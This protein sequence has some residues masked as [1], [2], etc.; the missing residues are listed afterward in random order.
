MPLF[1]ALLLCATFLEAIEVANGQTALIRFE[2]IPSEA[3][4][5]LGKKAFPLLKDPS[6]AAKR[7]ALIPIDYHTPEG[8]LTLRVA[9]EGGAKDIALHVR[10]GG[11]ASEQIQVAKEKVQPSEAQKKR[12]QKEYAE[13]MKIYNTATPRRYWSK[14]FANPMDSAITSAFG[15]ARLFN[16]MLKSFHSGTDFRAPVGTPVYATNDGVVVLAK[17]RFYAGNSVIVDHGEGLYS[18]YYHL[19][20]LHVKPGDHV[21]QGQ[22]L[23]FSGQSGRVSGP[24]LHYALMLQGV[25]VNP[26][27]LHEQIATL[28][29][30]DNR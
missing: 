26:L 1:L 23:G 5:H 6:D 9:Y 2:K 17:D 3:T 30:T 10:A 16:G 24:H 28:F 7:F 14:P 27:Q 21:K 20:V 12:T 29:E 8:N 4:L 13:A 19:S 18:C 15:T 11:Y 22:E 25:Q